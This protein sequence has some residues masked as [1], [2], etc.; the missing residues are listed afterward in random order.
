MLHSNK[1]INKL[2]VIVLIFQRDWQ[3]IFVVWWN[4]LAGQDWPVGHWFRC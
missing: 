1:S 4:G 3:N 2:F